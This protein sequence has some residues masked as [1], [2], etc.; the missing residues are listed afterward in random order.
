MKAD[1]LKSW[2]CFRTMLYLTNQTNLKLNSFLTAFFHELWLLWI[3]N[4]DQQCT[5]TCRMLWNILGYSNMQ[6]Q[7]SKNSLDKTTKTLIFDPFY[8]LCYLWI[9]LYAKPGCY[10]TENLRTVYYCQNIQYQINLMNLSLN[11]MTHFWLLFP[12]LRHIMYGLSLLPNH[13]K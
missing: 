1:Q 9:I 2:P 3:F 10:D 12:W 8:K 13:Y 5:V 6:Y 11:K 7:T 4:Y